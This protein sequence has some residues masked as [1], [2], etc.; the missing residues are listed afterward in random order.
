MADGA[1][2]GKIESPQKVFFDKDNNTS[3]RKKWVE[4]G[5]EKELTISGRLLRGEKGG[6]LGGGITGKIFTAPLFNSYC[7]AASAKGGGVGELTKRSVSGF[8]VSEKIIDHVVCTLA[9]PKTNLCTLHS[10]GKL[11][12]F[13][14]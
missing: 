11:L 5:E 3:P 10:H 8:L 2:G 1:N 4:K 13:C 14:Y 12:I 6:G 9:T 7:C